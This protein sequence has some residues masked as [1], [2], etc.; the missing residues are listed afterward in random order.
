MRDWN[1][2]PA[3]FVPHSG[4]RLSFV[5]ADYVTSDLEL[6]IGAGEPA[7]L[8]MRTTYGLRARAMR[9]F[10]RFGELGKPSRPAEFFASPYLR[11]FY[12]NFLWLN[13]LHSKLGSYR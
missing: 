7:A 9:L 12:P 8:A 4:R 5:E 3:S 1:S 2:D 10:Y 13:V 11:R 6:E